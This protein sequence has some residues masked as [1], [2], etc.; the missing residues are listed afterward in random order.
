MVRELA[1]R[2]LQRIGG[3][4]AAGALV[5][6]LDDPEPNVRAA[7][8]KQFAEH[9]AAKIVKHLAEYVARETDPDLLVH[10]VR[11]LRAVK[12]VEAVACLTTLLKHDNWRVRAEAAEGI[13]ECLRPRT[14]NVSNDLQADA[15]VALLGL[16][17]DD[18]GFVVSRAILG[19]RYAD[20]PEAV[21]P[22]AKAAEKHPELA[23]EAVLTMLGGKSVQSKA[24][25]QLHAWTDHADP[26]LRAA[27]L[28]G[29]SS[30]GAEDLGQVFQKLIADA[31][32]RVR[33]AVAEQ[34][35]QWFERQRPGEDD[36]GQTGEPRAA[37]ARPSS[38]DGGEEGEDEN[39]G[40]IADADKKDSG[41]PGRP[42]AGN[43]SRPGALEA[44]LAG[45]RAGD[46]RKKWIDPVVEPLV[47][48]L[49][50][51]SSAERAAAAAALV[52]LGRDDTALPVLAELVD[53]QGAQVAYAV[54]ALPWLPWK[55]RADWFVRL[56]ARPLQPDERTELGRML[57]V[58]SDPRAGELLWQQLAKGRLTP[59]EAQGL[60]QNL[61]QTYKL[62]EQ[63]HHV[64]HG[65]QPRV[66]PKSW[67]KAVV[68]VARRYAAKGVPWQ[69]VVALA[70]LS[71]ADREEAARAAAEI[72]DDQDLPEELRLDALQVLL[73]V[74]APTE[75]EQD[76]V[77]AMA[78]G[79]QSG[80][81]LALVYLARGAEALGQLRG[82]A[83]DFSDI[84]GFIPPAY[85]AR[86]ERQQEGHGPPKG[87][88]P[89]ALRPF[90][91]D[92]DPELAAY[93][94][95]VL[96]LLG[97]ADGLPPLVSQWRSRRNQAAV[98]DPLV[99][100]AVAAL[101]DAGHVSV[102]EAIYE[103]FD[104]EHDV[105][106]I[107]ELYWNIRSLGGQEALKLRKRIR[108]EVGM[109]SLR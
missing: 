57:V 66:R 72:H 35:F 11:V 103:S 102:L 37:S 64:S 83:L 80:R 5:R 62:A 89:E 46:G 60:L 16:L 109:D 69:R 36:V 20:I 12:D 95:Y 34:L 108:D 55:I 8:L 79:S 47:K 105:H 98:W 33:I 42:P 100:R 14:G 82:H 18:D 70:V 65:V 73:L 39:G 48:M 25:G 44:W 88:A 56:A 77:A 75:V 19:L 87:V 97:Q 3:S 78:G 61:L 81:R 24:V 92:A 54:R 29:L 32:S 96:A 17:D 71:A 6:L 50:A 22:V 38:D 84:L 13:G 28:V 67:T 10:A 43:L 51:D 2:T 74:R 27:A 107:K 63:P 58:L 94:G 101:D 41:A 40:P 26:R 21:E 99:E 52:P 15:H 104:R 4:R 76:V 68:D 31:D 49:A 85:A 1:L 30:A 9:P 86:M 106:R 91:H 23:K 53:A 93:A 45:F 7:V 90:L 59:A